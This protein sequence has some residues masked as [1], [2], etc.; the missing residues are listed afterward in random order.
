MLQALMKWDVVR[1]LAR[2]QLVSRSSALRLHKF[3]LDYAI[4]NKSAARLVKS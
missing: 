4:A 2:F 1:W 3:Q